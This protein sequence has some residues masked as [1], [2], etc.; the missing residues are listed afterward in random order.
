MHRYIPRTKYRSVR[1][2]FSVDNK[3]VV[4]IASTFLTP[5]APK[6]VPL[7]HVFS[8]MIVISDVFIFFAALNL[9]LL[10]LLLLFNIIKYEHNE[11]EN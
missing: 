7:Y 5:S 9:L 2:L 6:K 10:L 11:I 4:E 8:I 3:Y 1:A